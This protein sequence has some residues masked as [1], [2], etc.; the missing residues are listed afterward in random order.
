[1]TSDQDRSSWRLAEEGSTLGQLGSEEGV[2]VEDEEHQGGARITLERRDG[3][4]ARFAITCGLY[5]WFFHTRYCPSEEEAHHDFERMK[6]ELGQM[7]DLLSN[8]GSSPEK[9]VHA[10]LDAISDFVDHFPT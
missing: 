6:L 10:V 3:K 7:A 4:P 1:M 8:D 5:G 2:V 9:I